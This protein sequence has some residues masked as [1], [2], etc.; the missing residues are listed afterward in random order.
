MLAAY[1]LPILTPHRTMCPCAATAL[2]A[3]H[4]EVAQPPAGRCLAEAV[5]VP[6]EAEIATSREKS[7][8]QPEAWTFASV[9]GLIFMENLLGISSY[10]RNNPATN[11]ICL[12]VSSIPSPKM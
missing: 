7:W 5:A 2:P 11:C 9:S 6:V 8:L 4:L 1:S 12:Q 10:G 3:G